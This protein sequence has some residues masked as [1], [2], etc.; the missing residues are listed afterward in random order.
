M[1]NGKMEFD[2]AIAAAQMADGKIAGVGELVGVLMQKK[3]ETPDDISSTDAFSIICATMEE[4]AAERQEDPQI[5]EEDR[6][7]L[8]DNAY[9]LV[10]F[11][12]DEG[13]SFSREESHKEV[14][15]T[16]LQKSTCGQ[17]AVQMIL[18]TAPRYCT[19]RIIFPGKIGA[20][21]SHVVQPFLNRLNTT[22]RFGNVYQD[23]EA[24]KVVLQYSIPAE[25]GVD[26]E[27]LKIVYYANLGAAHIHGLEIIRLNYGPYFPE[28][29][30]ELR[31]AGLKM[32]FLHRKRN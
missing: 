13:V 22:L 30:K 17:L 8:E 4:F 27:A 25:Q 11:L 19:L 29:R 5:S 31:H 1:R 26:I 18:H 32:L 7:F 9:N 6:V 2:K 10:E 16:F 14:C 28:E 20:D 15:F 12:D 24:S 21:R 3:A 23:T